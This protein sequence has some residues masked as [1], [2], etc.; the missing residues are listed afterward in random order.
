MRVREATIWQ[1]GTTGTW[2]RLRR[3]DDH[4]L[5]LVWYRNFDGGWRGTVRS[6]LGTDR[7]REDDLD[8][9]QVFRLATPI[10]RGRS[11]ALAVENAERTINQFLEAYAEPL[12]SIE[13]ARP[14][15]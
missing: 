6:A 15:R 1:I 9:A 4:A 13:P 2:Y 3:G 7:F 11:D 5:A 12:T 8:T 10:R 14:D